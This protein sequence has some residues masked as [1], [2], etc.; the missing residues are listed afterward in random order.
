[1][2]EALNTRNVRQT[3]DEMNGVRESL[4]LPIH[5]QQR[6]AQELYGMTRGGSKV[7]FVTCAR[8]AHHMIWC[9]CPKILAP[10]N[11]MV[12]AGVAKDLA[13]IHPRMVQLM[14]I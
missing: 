9:E 2:L 13:E 5:V 4:N 12:L 11:V 6:D 8:C 7:A 3:V 1:M 10:D 14:T